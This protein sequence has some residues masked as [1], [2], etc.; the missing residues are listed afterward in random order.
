MLKSVLA[1]IGA[2]LRGLGYVFRHE[3]NFQRHVGAAVGAVAL[4]FWLPLRHSE[5]LIIVLLIFL[6]LILEIVNTALEKLLDT[7]HPRLRFAV[8]L[9]KD[10]MAASVLLSALLSLVVGAMIFIPHL[11]ERFAP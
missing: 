5:W 2:A 9:V 1:S 8:G 6:V 11:L 7:V 10:I 4:S 3:A